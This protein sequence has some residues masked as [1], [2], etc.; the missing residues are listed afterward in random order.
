VNQYDY[1]QLIQTP[2]VSFADRREKVTIF[3]A[4]VATRRERKPNKE[5]SP[6]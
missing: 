4:R 6:E 2:L 3:S 5:G 1:D